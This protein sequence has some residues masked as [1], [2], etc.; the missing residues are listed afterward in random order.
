VV[1]FIGDGELKTPLPGNVM[2]EG[3]STYIRSFTAPII[4]QEAGAVIISKL[5]ALKAD[6]TLSKS[7]HL[8]SL[9]DRH[10][11]IAVC[12][13]CGAALVQ[14]IARTGANAGK[15]FLG[16]KSYPRCRYTKAIS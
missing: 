5:A 10:N 11:S 1:F 4:S 15:A 12:P 9:S 3:L 14:R 2:T 13:T 8:Q 16:C 7:S 6:S